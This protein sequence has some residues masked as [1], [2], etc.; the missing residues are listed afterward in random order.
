M[1]GGVVFWGCAVAYAAAAAMGLYR[2]RSRLFRPGVVQFAAFVGALGFH[3]WY[4]MIRGREV[5]R[6]PVTTYGDIMVF[7]AWSLAVAYVLVGPVYRFTIPG[8][9]TAPLVV[10]LLLVSRAIPPGG[11]PP[12]GDISAAVEFHASSSLL[13]YGAL[14][15]ACVTGLFYLIHD[16]CIRTKR[17]QAWFENLPPL[18]DLA[19]VNRDRMLYGLGLMS[20]GIASGFFTPGGPN[21]AKTACF[22]VMWVLYAAVLA[23]SVTNRISGRRTALLSSLLFAAMILS[24]WTLSFAR[25]GMGHGP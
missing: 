6:C 5:G 18:H 2:M 4:L 20:V 19:R 9:L 10:L 16:H 14:G 7:V 23:A 15:L 17:L 12:K 11:G 3:T 13:A 25:G 8:V 21:H 22:F 24:F 1:S